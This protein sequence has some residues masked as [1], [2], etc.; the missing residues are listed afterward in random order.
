MRGSSSSRGLLAPFLQLEEHAG[1]ESHNY[2]SRFDVTRYDAPGTDD[3]PISDGYARQQD[4]SGSEPNVAS[5]PHGFHDETRLVYRLI[6]VMGQGRNDGMRAN[7]GKIL[8]IDAPVPPDM[9]KLRD[10]NMIPDSD[11]FRRM[12]DNVGIDP[13]SIAETSKLIFPVSSPEGRPQ[14]ACRTPKRT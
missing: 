8:D 6:L 2:R 7:N 3:R 4:G 9:N 12:D 5:N 14:A 11:I 10:L 1:R 13:R